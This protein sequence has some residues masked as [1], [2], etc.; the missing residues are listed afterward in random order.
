MYRKNISRTSTAG[1][2]DVERLLAAN[3]RKMMKTDPVYRYSPHHTLSIQPLISPDWTD[4]VISVCF[5]SSN[6]VHLCWFSS[7]AD[8]AELVHWDP[9]VGLFFHIWCLECKHRGRS[10]RGEGRSWGPVIWYCGPPP[11]GR[12]G[13]AKIQNTVRLRRTVHIETPGAHLLSLPLLLCLHN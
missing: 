8:E 12:W 10:M 7:W 3:S 11:K 5:C 13:A 9:G 2:V 1:K 4:T 6:D